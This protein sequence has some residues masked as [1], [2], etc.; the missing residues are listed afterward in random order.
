MQNKYFSPSIN[1]IRDKELDVNYIPTRNGENAFNK[2]IKAYQ[3]GTRA[4]NI[5]GAYGSGKSAFILA[6]DKALNKKV[7]YFNSPVSHSLTGFKTEFFIGE[8]SSFKKSFCHKFNLSEDNIFEEFK[9]KLKKFKTNNT[10]LFIVVDEF[11]KYLEF[12]AKESP[13]EE[14]YFI[15]QLSEFVNTKEQEIILITT[16]HQS[17]DDYALDLNKAQKAEWNKVKGRLIEISFNEPVEQL[18]FLTSERLKQNNIPNRVQSKLQ[19]DLFKAISNADAFP[20]KDYFSFEFSQNLFPFDIL[21]ASVITL[22]FQAYGQQERSMFTFLESDDYLGLNDFIDGN[23]FYNIANTYDYLVYNFHSLLNSKYNPHAVQWSAMK[24]AIERTETSITV[25]LLDT[26]KLVKTIGLLS[27]FGRGGQ[28]ITPDFILYYAKIALEI[29]NPEKVINALEDKQIIRYQSFNKRFVLFKGT[30]VNINQELELAENRIS[31]D[32]GLIPH[33]QRYFSF[34]ILQ[35]KRVY[36]EK[37]TPRFFSFHLTEKPIDKEA[38]GFND[39]Y[40][41]LIFNDQLDESKLLKFSKEAKNNI[42]FGWFAKSDEIRKKVFE[43]EK[44]QS[45]RGEFSNDEIVTNELDQHLNIE[46]AQL[47]SAVLN[48][49]YGNESNVKWFYNGETLAFKNHKALNAQLSVISD[50]IFCST[51]IFRNEMMNKERVSGAISNARK[52]LIGQ[53][54]NYTNKE[55]LNFDLDKYPPERTIYLS[56]LKETGIHQR[57][58]DNWTFGAPAN[59]SF[60][61]LWNACEDFLNNCAVAPRKL[62]ALIDLLKQKPF[63]LKQG[64]IDFWVPI[65]LIVKQ[66]QFTFFEQD[67]FIPELTGDTLDVAMRQPQK[68]FISSFNLDETRINIF[69]QYRYFLNQIEENTLSTKSFVETIKPFLVFYKRLVPFTQQ[70]RN[71]SKD[72]RR[73]RDAI[74]NASNPEKVFFDEIPRALGFTVKDLENKPKLEQFAIQLRNAT[75]ELS[76]AFESLLNRVEEVLNDTIDDSKLSF[77]ANKIAL[78]KRFKKIRKDALTSKHK[79]LIQRINTPLEDRKSW[80][81]SIAT[82]IINKSLDK[83]TDD[84]EKSFQIRFPQ[85]IHELDNLTDISKD[86]IDEDKEEVLKFEITTFVKGVQ[87]KLIRMPKN[88]S[89]EINKLAEQIKPMLNSE[90]KQANIALLIKLLQEQIEN[91]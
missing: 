13:E 38:E 17:F 23:Q 4:F 12:A 91:E 44:I 41:N 68:Y 69:N 6:L 89:K 62:D 51:P 73:L 8:Y 64:F 66:N 78:Q 42:L 11:G 39:G 33:L 7:D 76:A 47:T 75:Q 59:E 65:F 82:V 79:V 54:I 71:L 3:Y 67:I 22:A 84:D 26:L 90:D 80:I 36:Y 10:G 88:K 60:L 52:K 19:K 2:I 55:N 85:L 43:I 27:I 70:T 72:A 57:Q 81:N 32:F 20:L 29:D 40:I 35:A 50:E 74:A 46:K 5:V 25:D 15:Q 16:L 9:K 56:L 53:I 45:V 61:P 21:S 58:G 1:I 14:M 37:G 24:E 31:K 18:L 87:K 77:P 48:D 30:N 86:E 34:P 28:K 63:K 83:Y 49:F